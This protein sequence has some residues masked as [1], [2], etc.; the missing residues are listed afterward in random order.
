M[1][2]Q[3]PKVEE[4]FDEHYCLHLATNGPDGPWSSTVF[5][6]RDGYDL[7]F[8]SDPTTRHAKNIAASGRAAA[9]V[10]SDVKHWTDVKG[11]QMEGAVTVVDS[12]LERTKVF[13]SFLLRYP[14]MKDLFAAAAE[15]AKQVG[16]ATEHTVYRFRPGRLYH[17]DQQLS[18]GVR[19]EIPIVAATR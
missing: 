17:I 16:H 18:P 14:F 4:F 13:G 3:D 7:F 15:A 5:Y 12:I 11:L 19:R 9:T 2:N 6:V 8:I 1:S 10:N